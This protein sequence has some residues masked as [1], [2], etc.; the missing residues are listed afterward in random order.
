[1]IFIFY[2]VCQMGILV[3]WEFIGSTLLRFLWDLQFLCLNFLYSSQKLE[4]V[5]L[6]NIFWLQNNWNVVD[7]P[8]FLYVENCTHSPK[9][10]L[11]DSDKMVK[12]WYFI[13]TKN[14]LMR[15]KMVMLISWL[16]GFL[17]WLCW[18]PKFKSCCCGFLS[19]PEYL[20]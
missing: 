13:F 3:L 17:F 20:G 1:M 8:P 18:F 5:F 16:Y 10:L 2:D 7:K 11:L 12:N 4:R 6:L 15:N 9:S 19:F 14:F